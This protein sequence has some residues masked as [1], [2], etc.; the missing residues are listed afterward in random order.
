MGGER[1]IEVGALADPCESRQQHGS[2]TRQIDRPVRV[3]EWC[4]FDGMATG[5]Y[6]IVEIYGPTSDH[7]SGAESS[8]EI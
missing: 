8:A 7:I 5:L 6:R 4:G 2:E 1:G 3:C